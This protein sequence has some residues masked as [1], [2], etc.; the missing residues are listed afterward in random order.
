MLQFSSELKLASTALSSKLSIGWA[1]TC[2]TVWGARCK[3]LGQGICT[4]R[5]VLYLDAHNELTARVNWV[6]F[7]DNWYVGTMWS[8]GLWDLVNDGLSFRAAGL[9]VSLPC[10]VQ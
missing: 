9:S 4:N 2:N 7:Y 6:T 3:G 10:L 8:D 5:E 1:V